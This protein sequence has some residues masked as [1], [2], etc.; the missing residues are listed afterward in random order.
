MKERKTRSKAGRIRKGLAPFVSGGPS[1]KTAAEQKGIRK[2]YLKTRPVCKVTFRLPGEAAPLA[3]KVS[4]VGEFNSW[5][6]EATPMKRLK[7]GDWAVTLEL[8]KGR[9]YRYRYLIDDSLWENDW[10]ADGYEPNPYG[11][12]DS[13]VIV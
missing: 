9:A 1:R 7:N 6:R 12:D 11:C 8:E 3:R 10:F 13:V 5:D 4:I 2:R